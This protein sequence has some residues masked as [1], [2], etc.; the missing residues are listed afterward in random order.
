MPPTRTVTGLQEWALAPASATV[1]ETLSERGNDRDEKRDA[2]IH[3][4]L[5]VTRRMDGGECGSAHSGRAR[6]A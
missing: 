4:V 6:L 5:T 3:D 1:R 2:S